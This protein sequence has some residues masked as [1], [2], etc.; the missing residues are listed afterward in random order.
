MIAV[1]TGDIINS[2]KARSDKWMAL[3]KKALNRYGEEPSNW[4]IYRG[5][6]FQLEL[7]AEKAVECALYLKSAIRQIKT[8]DVRLA[9]G[10]GEKSVSAKK[11]TESHGSA[12]VHSGECFEQL[13]KN[14]LALQSGNSE[15]DEEINLYFKLA[16]LTID[17][18]QIIASEV[19]QLALEQPGLTQT[20]LAGKMNKSQS[21][22]SESLKRLGYD[23]M[24]L[25]ND[26]FKKLIEKI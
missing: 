7:P 14:T 20:E 2:R 18:W 19:M 15:L 17:R 4:E 21:T 16:L 26:R 25:L 3:L 9:I 12:F 22:I 11:I 6:S 24:M 10:L 13:K 1:I 5:D 8:L 23:E